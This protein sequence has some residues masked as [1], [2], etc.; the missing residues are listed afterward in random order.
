LQ[1]VIL[2]G[3]VGRRVFPLAVDKPKPMFKVLGKPL[4]QYVVEVLKEAG[5]RD[6]VIVTGHN[7]EQIRNHFKDGHQFNV[8]IEYTTQKESL[9]M[10][11][12]L[13]TAKGLVGDQFFVVNADDIFE[14]SLIKRIL[15]QHKQSGAEV[16]LSCKP[17]KET[18]KFGII[19]KEKEKVTKFVEKPPKGTE[20]SNL[21]VIGAY[22]LPNQIFDY[23]QEIPVS[24]HQYEDAI[25]RFIQT[26]NL[27]S[28]VVYDGF[29]AGYKFPW[30]LFAINQYLMDK[31]I[32]TPR[33]EDDV[34]VSEK[35]VVEG[36]VW[37]RRGSKVL[38][39]SCIRGPCYIGAN[40]YVGNNSLVWNY[41]SIGN[42]CVVGF[43]T[44]IKHSLIGDNCWFHMNY[45]GDSI[46]GDDCSFGAGTITANFRFDEKPVKVNLDGR[47]VDSGLDKFGALIGDGS[48][49]GINACLAPGVK[50]GP[51]SIVGPHVNLQD[52]L[53]PGKMV[54]VDRESYVLK[55]NEITISPEKRQELKK[56]LMKY[57]PRGRRKTP[58]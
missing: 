43:S 21:A 53:R 3:G 45:I 19:K 8:H 7:G 29:F 36:N 38:E 5:L 22:V 46:V 37:I 10:A 58:I 13:E 14:S 9:G 48:K 47:R 16:V 23:Y 2:A 49:T 32:K 35:A 57:K 27:V 31:H 30:D 1:A 44:E 52:D 6:L 39:G 25:E 41:S 11:N 34:N 40:S 12:A 28:A 42:N 50:I 56:K 55:E 17:V 33:I 15:D 26:G 24:D 54:L 20:P 18:W 4:I 51:R